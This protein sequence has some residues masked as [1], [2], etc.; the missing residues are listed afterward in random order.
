M[1]RTDRGGS[2]IRKGGDW[3]RKGMEGGKYRPSTGTEQQLVDFSHVRGV[4]IGRGDKPRR[5]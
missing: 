1:V 3:V 5:A 4:V 2:A